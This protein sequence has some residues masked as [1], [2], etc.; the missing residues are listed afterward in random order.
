MVCSGAGVGVA[1]GVAVGGGE[2]VGRGV[3]DCLGVGVSTVLTRFVSCAAVR[4][5]KSKL[6]QT[7]A[8]VKNPAIFI[9]FNFLFIEVILKK[10]V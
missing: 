4:V 7:S 1:I 9:C 6:K 10:S 3:G 8:K 5:P 2:T